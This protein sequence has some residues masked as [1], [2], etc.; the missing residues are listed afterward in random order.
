MKPQRSIAHYRIISKIGEGGM[1]EVYRATDTSSK[2]KWRIK[3][4]PASSLRIRPHGALLSVR[5]SP[6]VTESS[7]HRL[8]PWREDAGCVM[9]L[10]EGETLEER[11]GRPDSRPKHV[12]IARQI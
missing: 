1:G 9:E 5:R 6:G 11:I 7:E 2:R 8:Y 12:T 4:L 10:V 3:V